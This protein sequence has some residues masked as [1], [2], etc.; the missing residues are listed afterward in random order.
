MAYHLWF[1]N[2]KAL[3]RVEIFDS[4]NA[5]ISNEERAGFFGSELFKKIA[6]KTYN[7][8]LSAYNAFNNVVK[9]HV[10]NGEMLLVDDIKLDAILYFLS[11]D[12]FLKNLLN[13]KYLGY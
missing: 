3:W 13:G 12:Y 8:I 5:E 1:D 6:K 11:L 2:N 9:Q 4:P 7:R 10:D